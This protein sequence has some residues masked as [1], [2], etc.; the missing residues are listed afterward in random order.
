MHVT[1]RLSTVQIKGQKIRSKWKC[2]KWSMLNFYTTHLL[3]KTCCT[4][5]TKFSTLWG[6]GYKRNVDV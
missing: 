6:V 1:H 4:I 2:I 5:K 3:N